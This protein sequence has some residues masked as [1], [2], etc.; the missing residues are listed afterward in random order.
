M[1]DMFVN[2]QRQIILPEIGLAGQQKLQQSRVLFVGAGGLACP[3]LLYLAACGIGT[4]GIIDFD[5]IEPSNLHRQILYGQ[6]DIGKLKAIVAKD[7]LQTLHPNCHVNAYTSMLQNSNALTICQEYNLIIDASD[8]IETRYIIE[9]ACLQLKLPWV[10]A[11]IHKFEA[12][13]SVFNYGN[14]KTQ[15][16]D[17]FPKNIDNQAVLNCAETGVLGVLPGIV[18][19]LQANEALKIILQLGNVLSGTLLC[20]NALTNAFYSIKTQNNSPQ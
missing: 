7:K 6:N 19:S 1:S 5:S 10:F 12:Q 14:T 8:N 3:A 13:I 9:T 4:I 15:Y 16:T 18:G 2:Y 17:I 20:F 11:A